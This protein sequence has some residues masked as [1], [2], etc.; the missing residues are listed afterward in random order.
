MTAMTAAMTTVAPAASLALCDPHYDEV[1]ATREIDYLV[2][3]D[4]PDEHGR[5]V[6][7]CDSDECHARVL[8]DLRDFG[9]LYLETVNR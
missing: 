2:H 4:T 6:G 5:S 8:H 9:W 3:P 7:V 1:P